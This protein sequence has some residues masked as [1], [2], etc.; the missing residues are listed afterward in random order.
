MF[1]KLEEDLLRRLI[2][3]EDRGRPLTHRQLGIET[4]GSTFEDLW[5][6]M[7]IVIKGQERTLS[8]V[9]S[10]DSEYIASPHGR[11]WLS[12]REAEK[13]GKPVPP[14]PARQTVYLF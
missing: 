3:A 2:D 11:W 6:D 9:S 7:R 10:P 12:K 8:C 5:A 4:R 1:A 13:A 14:P